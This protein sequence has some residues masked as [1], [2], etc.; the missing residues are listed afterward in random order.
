MKKLLPLLALLF[1]LTNAY[2]QN[3]ISKASPN[4]KFLGNHSQIKASKQPSV[5]KKTTTSNTAEVL[6]GNTGY[7]TSSYLFPDSL[8]YGEYGAGNFSGIWIHHIAEVADFKSPIYS[9]NPSTNWVTTNTVFDIDSMS[10][11][12][13][14]TRN[15]PNPNIVDTLVISLFDNTNSNNLATNLFLNS[16]GFPGGSDTLSFI[17]LGYNQNANVIASATNTANIPSGQYKF[18]IPLTIVDTAVTAY[19]EKFFALPVPFSSQGGKIVVADIQFIPG[20]TYTLSQQIDATANAFF[21]TSLEEN[22]SNSLLNFFDCNYGSSQ[23]DYSSSQI[24]PLQVR[25]NTIGPSWNGHFIPAIAYTVPYA[26]E[27]HLISFHLTDTTASPCQVNSTFSI[28]ADTLNPGVYNAYETSTGNGVLSYLWD[29]GDGTSSTLQYPNHQYAIPGQYI[30]CLTVTS[31][32]GTAT[33]TDIYCDSSSVQKMAAGFLM[34]QFN[35]IAPIVTNINETEKSI[36][37]KAYPNPISDE[38]VIEFT[39]KEFEKLN[40]I[41]IDALGRV[42]LSN[43]FEKDKTT[44]NTSQLSKG[45]YNLNVLDAD[46]HKIKSLKIIK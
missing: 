12:Y 33:C 24:V 35:V 10:I 45:F 2:S 11:Y 37:I 8:G 21:F 18:K 23:C 1:C 13:A 46:G 41:L 42:V 29:F 15:H 30:V 14:Y 39:N 32:I 28:V 31:A 44:I 43:S 19:R 16:S 36:E 26:F 34:S 25:Y 40:Y 6:F 7:L 5:Y 22:G 9:I 4:K 3:L 27:H 20:Y 38:L 17:M